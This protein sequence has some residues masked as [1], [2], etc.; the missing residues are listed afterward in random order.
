VLQ[1]KEFLFHSQANSLPMCE[2]IQNTLKSAVF[3]DMAPLSPLNVWIYWREFSKCRNTQQKLTW[4]YLQTVTHFL[5]FSTPF[6]EDAAV[7]GV[8]LVY[9]VQPL[10]HPRTNTQQVAQI[11]LPAN[12]GYSI[13]L[14]TF[15]WHK[16][17]L[18]Y[19]TLHT[20]WIQNHLEI[21]TVLW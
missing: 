6:A 12:D 15:T 20:Y 1:G 11:T 7:I 5:F 2:N 14:R 3:W 16:Q 8:K 13:V 18:T 9:R 10:H 4:K 17:A 19:K 21:F